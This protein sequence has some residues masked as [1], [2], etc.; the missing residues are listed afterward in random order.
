M[1]L[2]AVPA[3]IIRIALDQLSIPLKAPFITSLGTLHTVESVV[4]TIGTDDGSVGQGECNPFWAI[5]G[6]TAETCV[7]VGGHLAKALLGSDASDIEGAHT[8]MDRLLFGN[9]S[10]KSAFDIALHDIA[11]QQAGKP[12][13]DFLGGDHRLQ[14]VTDYTVSMGSPERMAMDAQAIVDAGFTVIKVKVGGD[15]EDD[16]QRIRAIRSAIGDRVP[17]RIDANQGWTPEQAITVLNALGE[18]GIQHCEEPIPRWQFMELRRVKEASAI[19]IM[20][21][22]SCC[23]HRDAERLIALGACDRFNIK[24][25]KSGGLHKARKIIALAEAAGMPVQVGGFLESRLAWSAAAALAT[26]SSC[27]QYCDM[28]T[29]LMFTEDPVEGGITYGS[30]GAITLPEGHGLGA[31]IRSSYL[32]DPVFTMGQ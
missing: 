7:A 12:L 27:V 3:R 5:N 14:V 18:A 31:R 25:G 30:A 2:R 4:V 9:N 8:T 21:D 29:P 22:E 13:A 24:L 6:E 10:I 1:H 15:P 23:D 28:D 32:K 26:T 17:L 20:A 11:A 19:P 16:I